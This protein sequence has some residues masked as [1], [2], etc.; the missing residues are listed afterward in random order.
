MFQMITDQIYLPDAPA[1]NGLTFRPFRVETDYQFVAD[2][3]NASNAADGVE[4]FVTFDWVLNYYSHTTGFNPDRDILF[5]E[6][7]GQPAA[8]TRVWTRLLDDGTRLY[9]H[10]GNTLPKWRYQGIGHALLT[11]SERR[12]CEIAATQPV[13]GARVFRSFTAE[14]E[15]ETTALLDRKGYAVVRYGFEMAR[16]LAEPIPDLPLP[17][18]VEVRTTGPEHYRLVGAALNEAFR[19]HWGHS[20]SSEEDHQRWINNPHFQ[21]H[22]WQVAWAGNEV[23]GMVL[24]YIDQEYNEQFKRLRGWTDPI[25][26]RR[27]WRKQG[28]AKALITRSMRAFRTQGMTEVGLGVDAHNPNGALR[29]YESL[30]Y[31]QVTRFLTYEKPMVEV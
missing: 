30:G 8:F 24:N 12:L 23:A 1:I 18:G 31:R 10:A 14:R 19:D 20:E 25:C 26:V 22:L 16:S 4:D 21:P 6:I 17:L 27:P 29:L 9:M 28:L 13:T 5:A 3:S 11:W 15:I 7:D 2:L